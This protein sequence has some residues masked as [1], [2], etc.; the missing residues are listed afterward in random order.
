MDDSKQIIGYIHI[1]QKEGWKKSFDMLFSSIKNYG[2]YEKTKE[3]RCGVVNDNGCII[4][5]ERFHDEKIKIV[6][7]GFSHEYER[8]TLLHMRSQSEIDDDKTLYYYLHTKGLKHFGNYNESF[9]I[10]WINLML[11][12]NIEKWKL[13][14]NRLE[15]YDT[16]GCN[17]T[18]QHYSGNFWWAKSSHIK[19]LPTFI[20]YYYIAPE[21]WVYIKR[22]KA[23]CIFN[24]GLQGNGHYDNPYPRIN[25][26]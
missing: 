26:A 14:I 22:D 19:E 17:S 1:C 5:D 12:W 6:Y 18:G 21:D 7:V 9:I 8:P 3:I 2:L 24:S 15:Y 13:A 25:Y 16:Y 10:D 4:D 20:P 23:Y 11:Y